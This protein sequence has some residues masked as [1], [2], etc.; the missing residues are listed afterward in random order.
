LLQRPQG[1]I[2]V[3]QHFAILLSDITLPQLQAAADAKKYS[4]ENMRPEGHF[5]QKAE[6][7]RG[8]SSSFPVDHSILL[9]SL[10]NRLIY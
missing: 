1:N 8:T 10:N 3:K 9:I 6:T 5:H 4:P 7:W 2:E